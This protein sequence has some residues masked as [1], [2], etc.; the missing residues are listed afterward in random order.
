VQRLKEEYAAFPPNLVFSYS[1]V[2]YTLLGHVV[3]KVSKVPYGDYME[4]RIFGPWHMDQRYGFASCYGGARREGVQE[5]NGHLC[6]ATGC[7]FYP[8]R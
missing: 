2:G 6:R 5:K 8:S 7:R 3:E 4:N 1:N